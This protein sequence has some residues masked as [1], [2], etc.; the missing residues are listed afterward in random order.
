MKQH[1]RALAPALAGDQRG[2][3]GQRRPGAVGK[4]ALGLGQHLPGD[5]DVVRHLH[6]AERA[7][8][9]EAAE[10]LRRL[11]RERAAEHP[12]AATQLHRQQV[13][14]GV[15]EA[16]AGKA[17]QHPAI[18]DEP[19][20]PGAGGGRDGAD[21]RQ[22]QHRQALVEEAVDVL[23]GRSGLGDAQVGE[24]P[25]RAGDVVGRR[26]QRLAGI[27]AG[28]GDDAHGAPPP[29]GIEQL[30][31][32]GRGFA[33]NVDARHL[34]A[35]LDR[36][37][38]ARFGFRRPGGQGEGG[39]ADDEATHVLGLGLA[40]AR[41]AGLGAQHLDGEGVG[42][43]LGAGQ[44]EGS[45]GAA[46]YHQHLAAG[47]CRQF[48]RRVGAGQRHPVADI[49][50]AGLAGGAG[51]ERQ[52]LGPRRHERHRGKRAQAITR[53]A[54]GED[55]GLARHL[56]GGNEGDAAPVRLRLV[57]EAGGGGHPRRPARC[58]GPALVDDENHR[59]GAGGQA[60]RRV[61]DRPGGGED[62]QCGEDQPQQ[63]QPP[64]SAGGALLLRPDAEQ[65]AGRGEAHRPRLRRHHAQQHPQQ[66]Q[67]HKGGENQRRR[68]GKR[69][70]EHQVPS[71]RA[72]ER[73]RTIAVRSRRAPS[74][75]VERGALIRRPRV[76]RRPSA[77][78]APAAVRS[79]GDRC[80]GP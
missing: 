26:Q 65:Q 39:L 45:G 58:G 29:A 12:A 78:A 25:E 77:C 37:R 59:S 1:Q 33:G 23:G 64:R 42:A 20:Q 32:P 72:A 61:P 57:D 34:V 22:Y 75:S 67:R 40:G 19:R 70:S 60:R 76:R 41:R 47:Q 51:G 48:R 66:R 10:L 17:H 5:G 7:L 54:G 9:G 4:A 16:R 71:P 27:G 38:E 28:A 56:A 49:D 73:R 50:E 80:G 11:P 44:S 35:D 43:V 79:P 3:V 18:L 46:A 36:D 31:R 6:V 62:D 8:T 24:R 2:A 63:G 21:V 52:R 68:E 69:Q 53:R 14:L 55:G 74:R 13:V 15:G 30:H